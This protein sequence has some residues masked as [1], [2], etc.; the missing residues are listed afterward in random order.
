MTENRTL[1]EVDAM[2]AQLET[3]P[4]SFANEVILEVLRD[5][6]S[7]DDVWDKYPDDDEDWEARDYALTAVQWLE[8]EISDEELLD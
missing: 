4:H 7:E 3:Q 5:D 2:I 8:G 1:E 6:L